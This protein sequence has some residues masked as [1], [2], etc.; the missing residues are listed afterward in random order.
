MASVGM[1][2]S[3][4]AKTHVEAEARVELPVEVKDL[5]YQNQLLV[6]EFLS[7]VLLNKFGVCTQ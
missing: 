5:I 7:Y 6:L 2:A 3:A 4:E 1:A